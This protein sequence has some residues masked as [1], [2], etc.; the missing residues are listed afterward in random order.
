MN[1]QP[2]ETAPKDGKTVLIAGGTVYYDTDYSSKVRHKFSGVTTA[3]WD[4][5]HG[6]FW[7][8]YEG[9]HDD[10]IW[11]EPKYWM[12]LLEPPAD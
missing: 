4:S 3:N 5:F 10:K 1:W 8:G 9:T 11:H 6:A 2:I 12:P 7:S